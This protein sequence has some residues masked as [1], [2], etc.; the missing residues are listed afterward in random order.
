M[1]TTTKATEAVSR[2]TPL[3]FEKLV[4]QLQS[5]DAYAERTGPI[6]TIETHI[7]WIFLTDRFAYKLKKPVK[8]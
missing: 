4:L 2:H 7:S 8:T 1:V 6:E 3:T 5:T